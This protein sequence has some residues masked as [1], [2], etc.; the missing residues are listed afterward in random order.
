MDDQKRAPSTMNSVRKEAVYGCPRFLY[1]HAMQI[2]VALNGKVPPMQ[3]TDQ[4]VGDSKSFSFN[5]FRRVGNMIPPPTFDQAAQLVEDLLLFTGIWSVSGRV[6]AGR[7]GFDRRHW[8]DIGHGL[9]KQGVFLLG[10]QVVFGIRQPHGRK[11]FQA[12][13]VRLQKVPQ[14]SKRFAIHPFFHDAE[15]KSLRS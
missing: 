14:V 1:P 10:S 5:I 13:V 8:N 6:E 7:S 2:E 11:L 3:T 15:P 9:S 4:F 12:N